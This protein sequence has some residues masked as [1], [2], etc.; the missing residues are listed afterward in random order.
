MKCLIVHHLE[1]REFQY[2][3]SEDTYENPLNAGI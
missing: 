1:Q 2:H 3:I